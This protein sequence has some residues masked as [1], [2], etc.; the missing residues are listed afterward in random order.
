MARTPRPVARPWQPDAAL[1]DGLTVAAVAIDARGTVIY[2]NATAL[3]LFGSPFDQLV[4]ADARLRLFDAPER[5][6]VDQVLK[7]VRRTG[8]WTGELAMLA[9]GTNP[10]AMRTSWTQLGGE[11]DGGALMLIEGTDE[12]SDPYAPGQPLG[13]RLRRL[14]KVTSELLA[15]DDVEAVSAIVTDHMMKAAGATAASLS[16]LVDEETLALMALRGGLEETASRWATYP[17]ASNVPTAESARCSSVAT[18]STSATP[19]S[20]GSPTAPARSSVSRWSWPAAGCWA[21]CPCPSPDG[22]S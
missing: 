1:L 15:A 20:A 13:T 8:S 12:S 9:G 6:A 22:V 3:D 7:L 17:L 14:A 10:V 2:A 21:P 16:L 4:D 18:T 5:G 19:T 11:V